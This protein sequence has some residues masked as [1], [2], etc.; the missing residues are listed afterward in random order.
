MQRRTDAANGKAVF[1]WFLFERLNQFGDVIGW[2]VVTHHQ[3]A[4]YLRQNGDR[5]EVFN[6]I[7]RQL[8]VKAGIDSEAGEADQ[9]FAAVFRAA[10]HFVG[11]DVAAGTRLVFN[12]DGLLEQ[13]GHLGG[14][15]SSN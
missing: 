11:G 10:S 15:A 13:V 3:Y 12:D 9:Q 6:G 7:E 4:G 1:T 8:F 5:G 14:N 2:K